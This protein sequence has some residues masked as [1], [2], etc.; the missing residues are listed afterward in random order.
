MILVHLV[1]IIMIFYDS[2]SYRFDALGISWIQHLTIKFSF[3]CFL[4]IYI[5]LPGADRLKCPLFLLLLSDRYV[6][7]VKK[8]NEWFLRYLFRMWYT[9]TYVIRLNFLPSYTYHLSITYT[10]EHIRNISVTQMQ[11]SWHEHTKGHRK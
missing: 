2:N 9:L 5:H 6:F 7:S 11:L 1:F 4:Y 3:F 8:K 10:W